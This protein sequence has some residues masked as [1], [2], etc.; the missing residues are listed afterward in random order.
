VVL[1]GSCG[2]AIERLAVQLLVHHLGFACD[3]PV[4]IDCVSALWQSNRSPC[5]APIVG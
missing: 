1:L 5:Q 3:D 4:D 2:I